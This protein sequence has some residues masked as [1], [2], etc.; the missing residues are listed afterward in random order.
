MNKRVSKGSR[1]GRKLSKLFGRDEQVQV[2]SPSR[3]LPSAI[4]RALGKYTPAIVRDPNG[5]IQ[6]I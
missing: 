3:G 4:R 1:A 6:F 2:L 5:R